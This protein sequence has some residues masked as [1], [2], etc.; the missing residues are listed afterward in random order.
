MILQ[1]KAFSIKRVMNKAGVVNKNDF[2]L[3]VEKLQN[4]VSPTLK[5]GVPKGEL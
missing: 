5:V 3:I 1:L 2:E 4:I